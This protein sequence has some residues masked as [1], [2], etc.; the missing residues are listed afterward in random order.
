MVQCDFVV[1]ER[2]FF[3][4]GGGGTK[5]REKA[6][7]DIIDGK[8]I[9]GLQTQQIHLYMNIVRRPILAGAKEEQKQRENSAHW[10]GGTWAG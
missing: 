2:F 10:R 6:I 9:C 8:Y 7:T 4:G 1:R 5:R 3:S